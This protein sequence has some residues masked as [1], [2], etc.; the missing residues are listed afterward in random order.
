M[1]HYN[2][3]MVLRFTA[4]FSHSS[5]LYFSVVVGALPTQDHAWSFAQVGP[6]RTREEKIRLARGRYAQR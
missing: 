5:V 4:V 2:V 6:Q 1:L 3:A